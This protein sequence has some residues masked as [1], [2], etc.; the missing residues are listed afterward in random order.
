MYQGEEHYFTMLS[1]VQSHVWCQWMWINKFRSWNVMFLFELLCSLFE[2]NMLWFILLRDLFT[3]LVW[4]MTKN[5]EAYIYIYIYIYLLGCEVQTFVFSLRWCYFSV[6]IYLLENSVDE[7]SI[8]CFSLCHSK[9]AFGP[10][11]TSC[12]D[13]N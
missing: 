5:L 7:A 11:L 8:H 2:R 4:L 6:P 1:W 10:N 3:K 13:I 9:K 12:I